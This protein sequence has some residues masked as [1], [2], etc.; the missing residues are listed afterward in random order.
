MRRELNGHKT[1]YAKYWAP[2]KRK[3]H[4]AAIIEWVEKIQHHWFTKCSV[5]KMSLGTD[6]ECICGL[7]EV[8]E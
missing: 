4:I 2:D 6:K 8:I 1:Q 5:K 7:C 3:Q